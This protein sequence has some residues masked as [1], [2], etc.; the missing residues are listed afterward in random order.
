MTDQ[1]L[2]ARAAKSAGY[3]D[4]HVWSD[5]FAVWTGSDYLKWNP[6]EDD[7]DALR[8]VSLLKIAIFPSSTNVACAVPYTDEYVW[9]ETEHQ[10]YVC[11][12]RRAITTAAA[13]A[14]LNPN[15]EAS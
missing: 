9:E 1:E 10:S 7:G 13:R 4:T 12:L 15:E 6:L 5:K 11:A 2:L 14:P 8:L 3:T